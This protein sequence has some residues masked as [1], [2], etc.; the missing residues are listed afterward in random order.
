[1]LTFDIENW[2]QINSVVIKTNIDKQP[3]K[4]YIQHTDNFVR[5]NDGGYCGYAYTSSNKALL[6]VDD[7][8]NPTKLTINKWEQI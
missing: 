1:M 4:F 7:L 6:W 5:Q 3:T 8:N 2:E